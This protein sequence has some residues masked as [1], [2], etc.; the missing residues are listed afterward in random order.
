MSELDPTPLTE[1]CLNRKHGIWDHSYFFGIEAISTWNKLTIS[2]ERE[3][4]TSTEKA[5]AIQHTIYQKTWRNQEFRSKLQ[6]YQGQAGQGGW[7]FLTVGGYPQGIRRVPVPTVQCPV[8]AGTPRVTPCNNL[9]FHHQDL[10]Q[11]FR[12][13]QSSTDTSYTSMSGLEW[14][15]KEKSNVLSRFVAILQSQLF[16]WIL[17]WKKKRHLYTHSFT[18]QTCL[19]TT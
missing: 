4:I 1:F 2:R 11:T 18:S 5:E 9:N 16:P 17:L 13:S 3:S 6:A 7:M 14:I 19:C 8:G 12:P 15:Q 10:H